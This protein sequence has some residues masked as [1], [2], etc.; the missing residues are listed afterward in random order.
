MGIHVAVVTL[1]I[2]MP[3]MNGKEVCEKIRQ[4]EREN[5]LKRPAV[6][7]ISGNYEEEDMH[8]LL[9]QDNENRSDC[10]LMKPLVFGELCWALYKY[11]CFMKDPN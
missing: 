5:N 3:L 9:S 1:D 11:G 7:L 8:N 4:F 10:F 6:I 2:D